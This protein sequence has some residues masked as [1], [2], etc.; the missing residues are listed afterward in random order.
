LL[1]LDFSEGRESMTSAETKKSQG[2]GKGGEET[3][4]GWERE[5]GVREDQNLK[6]RGLEVERWRK[7]EVTQSN[8]G[9]EAQ[10]RVGW[11]GHW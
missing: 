4:D 8:L 11:F 9:D 3:R 10:E 5:R 7:V 1:L 2:G 6:I